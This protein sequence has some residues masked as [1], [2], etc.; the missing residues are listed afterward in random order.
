MIIKRKVAKSTMKQAICVLLAVITA[1]CIFAGCQKKIYFD[2]DEYNSAVSESKSVED[3][4]LSEQESEIVADKANLEG[5]LGKSEKNKKLVVK[6]VYGD[7][8]EYVAIYFKKNVFS[9]IM[10]YKYFDSESYYEMVKGYGDDGSDKLVE[11]DDQLRCLVYKS[12]DRSKA[13]YDFYYNLYSRRDP[14]ICTIIE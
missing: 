4:S 10:T 8:M 1:L 7:H 3:E 11:T 2:E 13:D 6:L 12:T 5:E 14:E 9:Y